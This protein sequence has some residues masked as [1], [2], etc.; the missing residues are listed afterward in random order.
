MSAVFVYYNSGVTLLWLP[1][2]VM[3]LLLLFVDNVGIIPIINLLVL[4]VFVLTVLTHCFQ[5]ALFCFLVYTPKEAYP[6]Y[7]L[8]SM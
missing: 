2:I 5:F 6:K 4:L 1:G 7:K 8:Y 3:L